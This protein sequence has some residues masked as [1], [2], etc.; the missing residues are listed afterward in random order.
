MPKKSPKYIFITGSIMSG[1]GKGILAA[2][3][4]KLLQMRG[5]SV[6]PIKF[7]GYLNVDCGTM[8]PFRHGEVFVLDDGTEVDMD[9]G[10][11]ERFLNISLD[12]SSSITGGKLFQK[13]ITKE[14]RGDYLGRDV[15]FI[16]HLANEIKSWIRGVWESK[17]ADI[18]LVEVGGTVG[19]FENG[20]FIEALRQMYYENPESIFIQL[21]YVPS[22]SPG[23][24]KTKPTQH[25][26]RLLQSMGI[27]PD[28]IVCREDEK[29][30]K[31]A[32][33]KISMYCNVPFE[34]VFDDPLV[35]TVYELPLVL[36]KQNI[37][38]PIA[39]KLKLDKHKDANVKDW[40]KIVDN[41]K[42]S[43]KDLVRIAVVGKY[44]AVKDAYVSIKEALIHSSADQKVG[45]ILDWV[46][47]ADLEDSEKSK[48]INLE[49][50]DGIIVPGGFGKRGIEGK[51]N[52]IKFARENKIPYLGLCLG[53]QL[54][55]IEYARNVCGL[56]NANSAE[57]D[58]NT[59]DP[60]IYILP[61]Q[62]QITEKGGTMR[63]GAY[64]ADLKKDTVSHKA[65]NERVISERHRH[66]YEV[67]P[68][69]IRKFE[70]NSL[71]ISGV[72]P[73]NNIVEIVEWSK[74]KFGF[75]VATQAH[76]ELKSRLE[77]PA[78]IFV[79]FMKAAKERLS[80]RSL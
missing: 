13:I 79:E 35:D 31:E 7:D 67:N 48:K 2:S 52:A 33:E 27:K 8:N 68:D 14:R 72:H 26:N 77:K 40:K 80:S 71:V 25:A 6:I 57:F 74:D 24:Q 70:E 20:Y 37:Y 73:K 55:V 28:M 76:I 15:Q 39:E 64:D 3:L 65:Y 56:K 63:L 53:M 19:D 59:P 18:V 50:Y 38:L 43:S 23:E 61:E 12:T 34:N 10:T 21:T 1:L 69:Y 75:G 22:L 42:S 78:P 45:V 41:I 30:S 51:I 16:P 5:Y 11:Y 17:D 66:R 46:E 54:M 44:T 47:A 9:F 49:K 60:V 58:K 29:L 4:S 32:K 36:E 62:M